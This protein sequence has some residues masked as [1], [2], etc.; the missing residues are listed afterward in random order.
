MTSELSDVYSTGIAGIA[1]RLQT[2]LKNLAFLNKSNNAAKRH[3]ICYQTR[4]LFIISPKG[5]MGYIRYWCE[6]WQNEIKRV[7]GGFK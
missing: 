4:K 7:E 3:L 1:S 6:N 2:V 5:Y